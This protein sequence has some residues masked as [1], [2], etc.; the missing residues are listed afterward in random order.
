M[1][2]SEEAGDKG[3]RATTIRLAG[4]HHALAAPEE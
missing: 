4:K 3:P 1:L 2:F